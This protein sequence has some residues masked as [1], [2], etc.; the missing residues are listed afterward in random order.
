MRVGTKPTND[1]SFR[2]VRLYYI[3]NVVQSQ[4]FYLTT[5]LCKGKIVK[6]EKENPKQRFDLDCKIIMTQSS[7]AAKKGFRLCT[8]QCEHDGSVLGRD[9]AQDM[10][11][12]HKMRPYLTLGGRDSRTRTYDLSHVKRAL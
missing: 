7:Q 6:S 1:K 8:F 2:V 9:R 12:G 10:Q 11:K 5:V 4:L 3:H